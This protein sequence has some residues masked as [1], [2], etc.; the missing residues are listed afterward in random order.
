MTSEKS[1]ETRTYDAIV[2]GSGI[3]GG[4]AAK[5]LTQSGLKTL[6]L[7]RGRHVW[8]IK[9]YITAFKDPWEFNTRLISSS[10]TAEEYPVQSKCYA[11]D[12]STRQFFVNDLEN[13]YTPVKPFDW[14]RGYQV[15]GR[16]LTWGRQCY[17]WSDL[18]FE[19]NLKDGVAIDWPVRYRD[20]APWYGYVEAFAGISGMP[21]N[22]PQLPDGVFMPP[23]DMT[24]IEKH[25]AARIREKY[26][27]RIMTIGRVAHVT[28]PHLGRG[29]CQY[30]N[31]CARGCPFGAYFSSNAVTI[32]AAE[33]TGNLTL[34]PFSI[35]T[36]VIFDQQNSRAAGVRILD[37]R[38]MKTEEFY[39]RIIFLN[40]STLGTAQILLNSTSRRFPN[41]LGNESGQL[42]HNLMDH[43][44]EAGAAGQYEGYTKQY[45]AGR[46]PN[47]AYIPRFQNIDRRTLRRDYIRGFA[48]QGYG[49]RLGWSRGETM[50]G[51]G[52][53]FKSSLSDPGPWTIW[54]GGRGE[55]LPYY[56]NQVTVNKTKP[57]KYG[58]PT[59]NIDCSFRE[60]EKAMRIDMQSSAAEMLEAAGIKKITPFDAQSTPG[61]CIHEMGTAR[62]GRDPKTSV[63]NRYNQM[64]EVKNVFVTDGSCMTSSGCQNPSLTYMALTA[65]ACNHA[66]TELKKGNL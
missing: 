4:W 54:L 66:V 62:M 6:L 52:A 12:E 58:L 22:L 43:H 38:D 9:D 30:R 42:G 3:S 41:G 23:M 14:I 46:R 45:Y 34:R 1:I 20:L 64:H 32:P 33:L 51:V 2:V 29:P 60:N 36:E 61:S 65:R 37:T 8:H 17:R 27:D 5:E 21:E 50:I 59:L 40:A 39:A 28:I 16:S 55:C 53:R 63:L 57:D 15:G 35:V 31:L 11:F 47:N 56:D 19:A 10:K 7:E 49:N 18:D 13:P 48:Y 44:F 24:C 25:V 26:S